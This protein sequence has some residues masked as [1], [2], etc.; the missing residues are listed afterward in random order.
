VLTI[1][2]SIFLS[3]ILLVLRLSQRGRQLFLAKL[4]VYPN[5]GRK[6][7]RSEL[8]FAVRRLIRKTASA[9]PFGSDFSWGAALAMPTFWDYLTTTDHKKIGRL[10]LIF[11]FA[12][13]L[14]GSIFSLLIRVQLTYPGSILVGDNYQLYNVLV[15]MHA[16][17]MVFM[18]V[19]PVLIGGFGNFI[20]P[21]QLGIADVAFPRVNALSF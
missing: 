11:G 8:Y 1:G 16:V 14:V 19:M 12:A 2:T 21:L 4:G 5:S 18:F 6:G 20:V 7:E 3:E 13:A 9:H 17:V 10:Y 15:T